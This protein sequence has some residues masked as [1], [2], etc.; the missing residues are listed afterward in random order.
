VRIVVSGSH[1]SGKSSLIADFAALHPEF[2]VLG[3][4]FDLIE[5]AGEEPDAG[6]FFA[7]LRYAAA[8]LQR[9]PPGADVI[10]ERGPL[11]FLAYLDALDVLGRPGRSSSLRERGA[12]IVAETA[13]SIDLLVLLPLSGAGIDVP[14][15]EDPALR[16]EMDAALL[17][18]ADDP[19]LVGDARIVELVGD[20]ARRL[21]QLL[22]ALRA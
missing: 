12:A 10:A 14:A 1:A 20:P 18:L 19:E 9:L 21:D 16:D 13:P 17:E 5:D 4:P 22:Q 8:R 6:T 3:D 15:D 2:D 7:Q 11:D